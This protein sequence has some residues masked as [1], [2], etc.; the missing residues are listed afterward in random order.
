MLEASDNPDKLNRAPPSEVCRRRRKALPD[1]IRKRTVFVDDVID[2][3]LDRRGRSADGPRPLWSGV[4][5]DDS[6][7]RM[8]RPGILH[9]LRLLLVLALVLAPALDALDESPRLSVSDDA[10]E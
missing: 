4:G 6:L 2:T 9:K 10:P 5:R 8:L 3:G 7:R 1:I